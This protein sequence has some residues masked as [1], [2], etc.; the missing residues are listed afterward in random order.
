[1]RVEEYSAPKGKRGS[2]PGGRG[3]LI[4]PAGSVA[5]AEMA[6]AYQ[7]GATY[8]QVAERYGVSPMT[9]RNYLLAAGVTPHP[10]GVTPDPRRY[11]AR[12]KAIYDAYQFGR[13]LK[14]LGEEHGVTR[15]RIR[16]LIARY[17]RDHG[18]VKKR[19]IYGAEFEWRECAKCGGIF[20]AR[21]TAPNLYC[22][23]RCGLGTLDLPIAAMLADYQAGMTYAEVAAKYGVGKTTVHRHLRRAG[24]P[25]QNPKARR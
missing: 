11:T 10:R 20:S 7:A 5:A 15:E 2:K 12:S 1:M 16:Q 9:V 6:A 8:Q 21:P 19:N 22:S 4:Y 18:L 23:R 13:T 17:E 14:Q 24:V 25:P 3:K